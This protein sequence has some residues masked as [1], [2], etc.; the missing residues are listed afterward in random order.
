MADHY[1]LE[2]IHFLTK[3]ITTIFIGSWFKM[4]FSAPDATGAKGT[5]SDLDC[6]EL[7]QVSK[8]DPEPLL[9][10]PVGV[11][12]HIPLFFIQCHDVTIDIPV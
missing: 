3:S 6:A 1:N 12:R 4:P 10:P 11:S 8:K 5:N 9:F 2:T 7:T